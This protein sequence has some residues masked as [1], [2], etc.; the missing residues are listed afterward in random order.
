M[1]LCVDCIPDGGGL[2][3]RMLYRILWATFLDGPCLKIL[4][5]LVRRRGHGAD[6]E[7]EDSGLLGSGS[8]LYQHNLILVANKRQKVMEKIKL[9]SQ[10]K[11]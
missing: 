5:L 11:E 9:E 8:I 3:L 4:V 6:D 1:C 10:I 7:D 2:K